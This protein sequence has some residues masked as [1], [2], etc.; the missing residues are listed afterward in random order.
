[1]T[2]C[3][4]QKVTFFQSP[5]RAYCFNHKGH[6]PGPQNPEA[7][8]YWQGTSLQWFESD[9]KHQQFFLFRVTFTS[10]LTLYNMFNL[11]SNF[12]RLWRH[13]WK[14]VN[15]PEM[16][17]L[18]CTL[19]MYKSISLYFKVRETNTNKYCVRFIM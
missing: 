5:I 11:P 17:R 9:W 16:A 7:W 1:M 14:R 4:I 19:Q 3:S 13:W 2:G 6:V 12:I 8:T 15:Q 10:H 18:H